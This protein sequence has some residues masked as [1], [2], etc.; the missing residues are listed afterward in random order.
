M[1]Y[2]AVVQLFGRNRNE[3]EIQKSAAQIMDNASLLANKAAFLT[4]NVAAFID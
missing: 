2:K 1:G 4:D 3:P